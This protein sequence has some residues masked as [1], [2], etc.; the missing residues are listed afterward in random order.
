MKRV[1]IGLLL[2]FL[3]AFGSCKKAAEQEKE[4][5][6]LMV[7]TLA[8]A[9]GNAF[10][11]GTGIFAAFFFPRSLIV[12]ASGNV[13]VADSRNARIRKITPDG[14]VTTFAGSGVP[15]YADGT[16]TTAQFSSR[17]MFITIDAK[18]NLYMT[19][20]GNSC[21]R[22]ITPAGVV[23]TVA[24]KPGIGSTDGP[25]ATAGFSFTDPSGGIAIDA[26]NTIFVADLTGI[27][28]ITPD[29]IV[30]TWVKSD[31]FSNSDGPVET[32]VIFPPE[33]LVVDA[34][35]NVYASVNNFFGS[36]P[37]IMKITKAGMVGKFAGGEDGYS[38]GLGV[39][40]KFLGPR[41]LGIDQSG[42]VYVAEALNHTIRKITPEGI[43]SLVAGQQTNVTDG[44]I[45][46][47]GPAI[48]AIFRDPWDVAAD[49]KGNVYVVERQGGL[50]RKISLSNESNLSKEGLEKAN[51]N[52]PKQWK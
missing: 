20:T 3:V 41:G 17:D 47:D 51:W 44:L 14:V 49:S 40:S 22:K 13:F 10:K 34:A 15:G 21:V 31:P 43:V 30:S 27:R 12:D 4:E 52:K 16:G 2:A 11:D 42:N 1:K 33:D 28:K 8:G 19:D 18:D 25:V 9:G 5:K 50:I 6:K 35:G 39:V 37:T 38:N 24:G 7:N 32:A 48:E 45:A 29:G 23:T 26:A 46:K 36:R